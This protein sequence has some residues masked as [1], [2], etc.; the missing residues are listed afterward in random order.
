M[1]KSEHVLQL[2]VDHSPAA[3]AVFD[4]EMKYMFASERYAQD[5]NLG[6]QDLI[7]QSHYDIFPEIPEH[8][9]K[10]HQHSLKGNIT[11]S[12]EDS[13]LR[14]DG[15]MEWTRWAIHPWYMDDEKVGGIIL[16]V[17]V[18][19]ERK[20]LEKKLERS[21]DKFRTLVGNIPGITYRCAN[22]EHW[23]MEFI[24]DN[25]K[26]LS[27]YPAAD[28]TQNAVRSYASIIHHDDQQLVEE[29]VSEGIEQKKPFTIEYRVV[30]ADGTNHWVY[31][32]GIGVF[33]K[34]EKLLYLDGVIIDI[35]DSK[36]IEQQLSQAQKMEAIGQLTGGLA[37]D[38]NNILNGL[39]NYAQLAQNMIKKLDDRKLESYL[40]E[41]INGGNRASQLIEDMLLFSRSSKKTESV[42]SICD[43]VSGMMVMLK[44]MIPSSIEINVTMDDNVS[45]VQVDSLNL[46]QMLMNLSINAMHAMNE[47][48]TLTFRVQTLSFVNGHKEI[49]ST[50]TGA[51]SERI[52]VCFCENEETSLPQENYVELSVR[53]TGSG[54]TKEH[55]PRI[56][57]PF[58]TTKEVGKGTGMGLSMMHGI[59]KSVNGHII[60]ETE[61]NEGTIF[62][63]LFKSS[64]STETIEAIDTSEDESNV[65]NNCATILLVDDDDFILRSSAEL[66]SDCGFSVKTCPNGEEALSMFK[67]AINDFDLVI[68]D[69][70]MP[71]LTG[72][73]LSKQILELR[74]DIPIIFCS[75]YTGMVDEKDVLA[76]GIRVYL[77]KPTNPSQL[78]KAVNELLAEAT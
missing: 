18:I 58:Y 22:D 67:S 48:G 59:M 30:N 11:K 16:F 17:E 68:T 50:L 36:L 29:I 52:D 19:T 56:F 42:N 65:S 71:K 62:R 24:S 47:M 46:E 64:E 33:D 70:T 74:S 20:N 37:H 9:K 39:L 3:I 55:L 6:V 1:Y 49:P 7:G 31:E 41:V 66:L 14:E 23:S 75:G 63:L 45:L 54:I 76:T 12:E 5:F 27:G 10:I 40:N 32:K 53:D 61:E 25:V 43:I 34:K 26:M 4:L 8:W 60:V 73:D 51:R 44:A 2:L 13:F 15:G 38:F 78:L 69:Q 35:T 72:I 21:E 28:F 57:E 77:K